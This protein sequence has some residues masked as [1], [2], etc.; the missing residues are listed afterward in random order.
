MAS[1]SALGLTVGGVMYFHS[2]EYGG[3]LTIVSAIL[4]I[5]IAYS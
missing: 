2:Y 4:I 5:S 3:T 1:F